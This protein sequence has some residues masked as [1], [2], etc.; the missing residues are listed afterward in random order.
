MSTA[1]YY[2]FHIF[3]SSLRY[4]LATDTSYHKY[5]KKDSVLDSLV[6]FSWAFTFY[7]Y[8]DSYVHCFHK[9]F[10]FCSRKQGNISFPVFSFEGIEIWAKILYNIAR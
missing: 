5:S 6:H 7:S 4:C 2:Y 8:R 10:S 9:L 1:N 3:S